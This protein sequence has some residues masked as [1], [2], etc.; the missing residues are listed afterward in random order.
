[1]STKKWSLDPAHSELQFKVKHMMVSNVTGDFQNFQVEVETPEETLENAKIKFTAE[2]DSVST[3]NAQR[4]GHLKSGDFFDSTKFPELTFQSSSFKKLN[5]DGEYELKG[6]LTIKNVTKPVTLKVN[7]GGTAKDPWGNTKAGF[8]VSGKINRKDWGL[9]YNAVLE[10]GGV[11]VSDE[12][13]ILAELEMT[14]P[15]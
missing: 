15:N 14:A 7:H 13:R 3:G 2:T 10:T 9:N 8:S 1:M 6:D 5:Q 11:L 4:D 12:V